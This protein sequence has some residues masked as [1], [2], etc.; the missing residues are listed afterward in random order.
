MA[1]KKDIRDSIAVAIVKAEAGHLKLKATGEVITLDTIPE[2]TL[3]NWK[4]KLAEKRI[5]RKSIYSTIE[6]SVI[7][8]WHDNPAELEKH[9]KNIHK[10]VYSKLD[11]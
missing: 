7:G 8:P 10:F 9:M 1:T 6:C 4:T 11:K 3:T 2:E 5:S